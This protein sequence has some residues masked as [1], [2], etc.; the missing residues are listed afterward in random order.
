MI[1]AVEEKE[2]RKLSSVW[3]EFL[4][5]K[6]KRARLMELEAD[7]RKV[8]GSD[9]YVKIEKEGHQATFLADPLQHK[10]LQF[11][12]QI[13]AREIADLIK[14]LSDMVASREQQGDWWPEGRLNLGIAYATAGEYTKACDF[15]E[16]ARDLA[17][18]RGIVNDKVKQAV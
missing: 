13:A 15:L 6:S 8:F 10:A 12:D 11:V 3:I 2:K 5:Q 9:I 4:E 18:G 16:Q 7:L 1:R 17:M 14:V